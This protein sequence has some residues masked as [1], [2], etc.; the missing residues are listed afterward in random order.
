MMMIYGCSLHYVGIYPRF[1][2]PIA[3]LIPNPEYFSYKL[4]LPSSCPPTN[5]IDNPRRNPAAR[6]ETGE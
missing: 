4:D 5:L 3:P 6:V 2:M 1:P